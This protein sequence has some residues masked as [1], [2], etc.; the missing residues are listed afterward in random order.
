M[1]YIDKEHCWMGYVRLFGMMVGCLCFASVAQAWT[2]FYIRGYCKQ[3]GTLCRSTVGN[4]GGQGACCDPA[5]AN[6]ATCAKDNECIGT[7]QY[8]WPTAKLPLS[9]SFNANN[10]LGKNGFQGMVLADVEKE[11]KRAW[12]AWT[13]P[14]C[15]SF[16]H[17]Y[18]GQVTTLPDAFDRKVTIYLATPSEWAQ[19]GISQSALAFSSPQN[20]AKGVLFDG[21]IV[22]SPTVPWGLP[23]V[24]AQEADFTEALAHEIGHTLG[25]G[26][27]PLKSALMFYAIKGAG[28]LFKGLG[29]DDRDA[30]CF[31]YPKTGS[32]QKN[33]DCPSC[34]SCQNNLCQPNAPAPSS[35]C[36]PCQTNN[37]CATGHVCTD[38]AEG[39]RCL[40][41][42]NGN[43]CPKGYRCDGT[44]ARMMCIPL[45]NSCPTQ[46]CKTDTEC[47]RNGS[48]HL[49]TNTCTSKPAFD[50]TACHTNCQSNA[51]CKQPGATCIPLAA[52]YNRCLLPCASNFFCPKGYSC[53]QTNGGVRCMPF[54]PEF[55]PCRAQSDCPAGTTCKDD[56]CQPTT[57]AKA[58]EPCVDSNTC[59]PGHAC[60]ALST[61]QRCLQI[62]NN[63][64]CPAG[65][66][67]QNV[68]INRKFCVGK[69]SKSLGE[70]C[71]GLIDI[72]QTGLSCLLVRP[73]STKGTCIQNCQTNTDC[74]PGESCIAEFGSKYCSCGTGNKCSDGKTCKAIGQ[75]SLCICENPPCASEPPP[76]LCGDGVCSAADKETCDSCPADC[77]CKAG[78]RCENGACVPSQTCGNGTCA[79]TENCANCPAD[80]ACKEGQTCNGTVCEDTV[81][82]GDGVCAPAENCGTCI[83]DCPC[84]A[85]QL[86][87]NNNCQPPKPQTCGDGI[88][89][90][91]DGES[92]SNCKQDCGCTDTQLCQNGICQKVGQCGDGNCDSN[93]NCSTCQQDCTCR[94]GTQCKQ[95]TCTNNTQTVSSGSCG[96]GVCS[97]A[98]GENCE[99]CRQDCGCTQRTICYQQACVS[100]N[101]LCPANAQT[102][103]CDNNGNNCK[104]TCTA[105]SACGCNSNTPNTPTHHIPFLALLSLL[106]LIRFRHANKTS[107]QGHKNA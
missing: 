81:R 28:P 96:D 104:L 88:C 52:G 43:C 25:F 100:P 98:D 8:K 38:T 57:K 33:D 2:P 4:S 95:G 31:T 74:Q 90:S 86:C 63:S 16:K 68:S 3:T 46:A 1:L 99:T 70:D 76:P 101:I 106:A 69:P 48:C 107:T 20:D 10:Q 105:V 22:V 82:C 39:A 67:C 56:N 27:T 41:P 60:I 55:C 17:T 62:C 32:C 97:L 51:D 23:P 87:Q 45:A 47:G 13:T 44:G 54:F 30:I 11:L 103:Q 71:D 83:A 79:G 84:P 6:A 37:D 93:E 61:G 9:W 34:Q 42:C 21:D 89:R 35:L 72:C 65:Q 91:T 15:T 75:A 18:A 85:G 77:G 80:C 36:K 49:A 94:A 40:M 73:G 66:N 19:L 7:Y 24:A 50:Y 5:A 14:S 53:R 58:G 29:Q 64:S 102:L 12:D 59:L 78:N 92:C 26:H